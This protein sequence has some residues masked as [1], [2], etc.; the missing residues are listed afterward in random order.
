MT[1]S[2]SEV[3][4]RVPGPGAAGVLLVVIALLFVLGGLPLQLLFGEAGLLLAQIVFLILPVLVFVRRGGF[5]PTLTLPPRMPS[6]AEVGGGIL[7]L[8]GGLQLA[9][10]LTWLQ[11]LVVPVPVEYLEAM[12]S[13]L[14]ADSFGRYLWLLLVAALLPA[15]AEEA[16]FRGVVLSAFRQKLPTVWAV[17]AVGL[18]FGIFHLTPQTAFRLVPT[19]WLGI[20]LAWVVVISGSLP[21]AMLLHFLN[22]ATVLTLTAIP[23][24]RDQST[25]LGEQGPPF[26]LLL[27]GTILFAFG[28]SVLLHRTREVTES[29]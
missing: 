22:N 2:T 19:A 10:F 8:L 24:V 9:L 6:G 21:L 1:A 11:S 29:G 13:V 20:L 7:F 14:E 18:V 27:I 16:L 4:G 28:L 26:Q 25:D 12:S 3:A 23:A 17:I 15:I 5:D